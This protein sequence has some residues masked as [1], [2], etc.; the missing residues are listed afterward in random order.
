LNDYDEKIVHIVRRYR[1]NLDIQ[2]AKVVKLLISGSLHIATAESCTG[3]MLSEL[4]TSV[5]GASQVFEF[6]ICTYSDSMKHRMLGVPYEEL[7]K[8]GAVSSQVAISMIKGLKRI[9]EA[10]ICVSVTG[11]AGPDGGTPELPAGT[12]YTAFS[13]GDKEFSKLL[14]LYGSDDRNREIIRLHTA[15]CVFET[16][17]QLLME[18]V[19]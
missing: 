16:V 7:E 11:Y 3:G 9:S 8:F 10:D 1:D 17:E 19:Q 13:C 4:I 12:V 6:G 14:K 2:V 15:L 18:E 5:P